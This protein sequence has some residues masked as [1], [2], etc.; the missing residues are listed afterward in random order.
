MFDKK[1]NQPIVIPD[2][3]SDLDN[4]GNGSRLDLILPS[5]KN[6]VTVKNHKNLFEEQLEVLRGY[7]GQPMSLKEVARLVIRRRY[8]SMSIK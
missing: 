4:L 6:Q 3:R 1:N 2:S 7:Y 8:A 5:N